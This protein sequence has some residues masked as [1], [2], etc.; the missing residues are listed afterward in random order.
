MGDP[1]TVGA[2]I[3]GIVVP[4]IHALRLLHDD[5]NKIT[6]APKTVE[7]LKADLN[8][9]ESDIRLLEAIQDADWDLLGETIASQS[10]EAIAH[11]GKACGTFHSSLQRWTK[12]SQNGKLSWR[13]RA[14]LGFFKAQQVDAMSRQLQTC[15][16]TLAVVVGIAN[17]CVAAIGLGH[18]T[19]F[20]HTLTGTAP[21][22]PTK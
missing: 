14:T 9:A 1:L 19:R 2:S 20:A 18:P 17:L 11:C 7:S 8:L 5:L 6:D 13:D 4:A 10:K 16:L 15:K 22:V 21:F 3:V 12:R